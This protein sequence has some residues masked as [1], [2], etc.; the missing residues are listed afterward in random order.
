M[1]AQEFTITVLVVADKSAHIFEGEY[2]GKQ[3]TIEV[4]N[5]EQYALHDA[6]AE[7]KG[8]RSPVK[9]IQCRRQTD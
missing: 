2:M 5:K 7:A 9:L 4:A 6:G 1:T 8:A 3:Q